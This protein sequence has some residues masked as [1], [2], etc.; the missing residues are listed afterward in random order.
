MSRS[1]RTLVLAVTT[2][3][4]ATTAVFATGA[5]ARTAASSA[6]AQV[7]CVVNADVTFKPGLKLL[8]SPQHITYKVTYSGCTSST[9]APVSGGSHS[10]SF[11]GPRG[12][13]ELPPSHW[14]IF[15]VNW[16]AGE[17]SHVEGHA[18]GVD[19]AGQSVHTIVGSVTGGQFA[20][21][22]FIEEITQPSL[23][24]LKC[25]TVGVKSQSGVGVVSL[26]P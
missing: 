3:L 11:Y 9:G 19:V 8:S 1:P 16:D 10:G 21:S 26:T 7:T 18:Q 2:A 6:S 22:T 25:A 5:S 24:L 12:C 15:D 13:A 17:D 14:M 20:G 4:I 23:D